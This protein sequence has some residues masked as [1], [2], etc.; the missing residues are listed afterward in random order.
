MHLS[1]ITPDLSRL[2]IESDLAAPGYS[3]PPV[4]VANSVD[5]SIIAYSEPTFA[6]FD[7][8]VLDD[9]LLMHPAL[10]GIYTSVLAEDFAAANKLQPTTDQ[11]NAYAAM[12]TWTPDRIV[13]A[14]LGDLDRPASA[15]P[16][17]LPEKLGL[18]ALELVV[19]TDLDR[20]PITQIID[21]R[22]RYSAEFFA[23]GQA[24]DETASE[25][26]ELADIRNI[27]ILEDYLHEIVKTRF[28]QPLADLEA[29][30]RGLTGD[31]AAMS[32]NVKTQVPA[33]AAF[34]GGAWLSG[35]PLLAGTGA[36]AIGLMAIRRGDPS[37]T[38]R[39][40]ERCASSKLPASHSG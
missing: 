23:F 33:G 40:A 34:A 18:L 37:T 2:L 19:P 39:C 10:V 15:T 31:A 11:E 1:E 13:T 32:I 3:H 25:I 20:V 38:S 4:G 8:S 27:V 9:W 6:A 36:I 28:E 5:G 12:N 22:K 35:Q 30:M 7:P 16:N 26:A 17:E 24:V 21:I 29:K 14:L